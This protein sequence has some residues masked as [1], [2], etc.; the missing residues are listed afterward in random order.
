[1]NLRELLKADFDID[2]PISGGTGN[3]IDNPII[4][5]KVEPNDFVS[6]E[7]GILRCLG[8]GR[9]I[10]WKFHKQELLS[11]NDNRFDKIS[12]EIKELTETEVITTVENYYFDITEC[13]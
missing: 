7:Y 8:E 9:G 5:H 10:E 4:I 12:I 11:H 6:L 13:F 2:F 1:M 3:S